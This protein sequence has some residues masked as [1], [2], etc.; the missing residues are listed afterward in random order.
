MSYTLDVRFHIGRPNYL[1]LVPIFDTNIWHK[2]V[3]NWAIGLRLLGSF[4]P[5]NTRKK[6][7]P[8]S[9]K[10]KPT[11]IGNKL[12]PILTIMIA[13]KSY[14][15]LLF[16]LLLLISIISNHSSPYFLYFITSVSLFTISIA[17]SNIAPFIVAVG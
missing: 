16:V 4:R 12:H 5:I 9:T 11:F 14:A 2:A 15:L 1:L 6:L 13:I 3:S 7:F 17:T 10:L 8:S